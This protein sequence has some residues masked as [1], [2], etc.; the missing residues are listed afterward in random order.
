M[1]AFIRAIEETKPIEGRDKI[2]QALVQGCWIIT[3][4]EK[5]IGDVGIF[6]EVD[7]IINDEYLSHNS[8]YASKEK[9]KDSSLKGYFPNNGRIRALKFSFG[10]SWSRCFCSKNWTRCFKSKR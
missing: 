4:K 9:N 2:H 3:S 10:I 5:N 6:F 8:L 7:G 1:K